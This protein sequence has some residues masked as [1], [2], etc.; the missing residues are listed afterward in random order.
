MRLMLASLVLACATQGASAGE[1]NLGC[2]SYNPLNTMFSDVCWSGI[3]PI[4]LAG[5]TFMEGK[6]GLPEGANK[7][8]LCKCGGDLLKGQLPRIGFSIG[9]WAPAKIIDVTRKP[10]CMPSLGGIQLPLGNIDFLNSGA[11]MG[12]GDR[13]Q[14]FANWTM[15]SF[16]II[17]MLRMIDEGA[18]PSDGLTDF[19]VIQA[20]PMFPNWNDVIG[21][22]TIFTN[23]EML[24]FSGVQALF[25][26]PVDSASST[27]GRPIN[28]LF[29][30]GGA[31]GPAYPLT[32]FGQGGD[33]NITQSEPVRASS[34]TAFRALSLMHRLGFLSETIGRQNLCER[35]RRYVVRKDAYRWQM[36]APS[37]ESNGPAPGAPPP[38]SSTSQVR[39]VNPPSVYDGCTHPTG[40]STAGWGMWRDVPAT[41]ED[42]SYLMFQWTD[43]CFGIY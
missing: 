28:S 27:L 25:A 4:R 8:V 22:Y 12:R 20:S 30:V 37:P 43:C 5:V 10:Y 21:R 32:G 16:P 14:Y 19:D 17:W 38:A 24:L 13:G 26:L 7:Q 11:N 3:F 39:E 40:A 35:N 36:L 2:N 41:G 34:L 31:W 9:F 18:C 33:P 6:S 42:H 29:W 1:M 23:P 15:Y